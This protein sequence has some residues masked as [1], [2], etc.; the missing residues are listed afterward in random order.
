MKEYWF[1]L[2]VAALLFF[3]VGYCARDWIPRD[4]DGIK[5]VELDRRTAE[6]LLEHVRCE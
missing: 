6:N 3:S 4:S 2:L 1:G 5:V